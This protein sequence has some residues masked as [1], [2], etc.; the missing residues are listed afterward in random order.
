VKSLAEIGATDRP[1]RSCAT[2]HAASA[3]RQKPRFLLPET[4]RCAK[5]SRSEF[6]P[7]N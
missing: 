3:A 7:M 5:K 2:E 1:G 4:S 6:F